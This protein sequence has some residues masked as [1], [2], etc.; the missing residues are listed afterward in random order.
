MLGSNAGQAGAVPSVGAENKWISLPVKR[1]PTEI[2]QSLPG[3]FLCF[4]SPFRIVSVV[5]LVIG[6][7]FHFLGQE[8]GTRT[9]AE[10]NCTFACTYR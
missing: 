5:S 7:W 10:W 2:F 4:F 9:G 3:L 8:I 6:F 1:V